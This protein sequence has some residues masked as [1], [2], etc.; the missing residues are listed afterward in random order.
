VK[1]IF[2]PLQVK[3]ITRQTRNAIA[4][5]LDV[6]ASLQSIFTF[7][8]GQ[9]LTIRKI[10][11]GEE[12]RRTYSLCSSPL[13]G[14]WTVAVKKVPGGLFSTW[15]NEHLH[16]E[17][18]KHY[19]AFA[20]GSGI[21]PIISI[22]ATVLATEPKSRFTLIY[23]NQSRSSIIFKEELEAL[24]NRYINRL[25]IFYL[26]S[27]EKTDAEINYGRIDA[28][29]CEQIFTKLLDVNS[30]DEFYLCGPQEMSACVHDALVN[31]GID[32]TKIRQELFTVGQKTGTRK[33]QH[34]A[35]TEDSP[36]S[37]ITVR[38]DGIL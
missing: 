18:G 12:T 23:S 5:E 3:K 29:K 14:K 16:A 28:A 10:I 1:P 27:R 33:E 15:A 20:A 25:S 22:I 21:T 36:K 11:N 19:A 7:Q 24:K 2:Y 32:S 8:P 6:P 34:I 31:R 30:V 9:Y 38:I 37:R 13:D 26:L 4:I 17:N 35:A